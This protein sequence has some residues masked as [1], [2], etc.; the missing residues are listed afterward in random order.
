M[1]GSLREQQRKVWSCRGKSGRA[2]GR[3]AERTGIGQAGQDCQE[4]VQA[5]R[6]SQ[7]E[8]L[9][10]QRE[11]EGRGIRGGHARKNWVKIDLLRVAT[12]ALGRAA[13]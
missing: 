8:L 5:G 10:A 6:N 4:A 1:P 13:Q 2:A 11:L 12:L 3:V 9:E 7:A